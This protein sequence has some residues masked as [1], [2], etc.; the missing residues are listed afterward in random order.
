MDVDERELAASNFNDPTFDCDVLLTAYAY[1]PAL[2]FVSYQ[3]TANLD[4]YIPESESESED[5]ED[6]YY[7]SEIEGDDTAESRSKRKIIRRQR[8][9]CQLL[10]DTEGKAPSRPSLSESAHFTGEVIGDTV[11]RYRAACQELSVNH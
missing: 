10:V 4:E 11:N 1:G 9:I 6:E 3:R 2:T 8:Q 7:S 5:S